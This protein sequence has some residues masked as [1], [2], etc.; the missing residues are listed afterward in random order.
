MGLRRRIKKY[1][2]SFQRRILVPTL[3]LVWLVIASLAIYQYQREKEI[4]ERSIRNQLDIINMNIIDAYENNVD[5]VQY[6]K[7]NNDFFDN[8]I[9]NGVRISVYSYDG[10]LIASCGEPIAFK[11]HDNKFNDPDHPIHNLD[12]DFRKGRGNPNHDKLFYYVSRTSF[13]GKFY[14]LTAMPYTESL[15]LGLNQNKGF[16]WVVIALALVA[17]V[18][19]YWVINHTSRSLKLLASFAND[20]AEGREFDHNED[21]PLMSSVKSPVSLSSFTM[22]KTLP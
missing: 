11:Y 13:D 9:Y 4:L 1:S 15:N 7:F 12:D 20:V 10:M 6:V 22:P 21:F 3:G 17:S 16:W 19:V 8:T 18:L 2:V 14:V 5:I